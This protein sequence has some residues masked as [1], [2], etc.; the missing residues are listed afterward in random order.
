[1]GGNFGDNNLRKGAQSLRQR[2]ES[3]RFG[4]NPNAL[5]DQ[6]EAGEMEA[7]RADFMSHNIYHVPG[8]FNVIV[9]GR[10]MD[11]MRASKMFTLYDD[12]DRVRY[13]NPGA[14]CRMES[15]GIQAQPQRVACRHRVLKG[16]ALI[17][18]AG[19]SS[20]ITG[21]AHEVRGVHHMGDIEEEYLQPQTILVVQLYRR[22]KETKNYKKGTSWI[23]EF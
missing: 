23:R 13:K 22:I 19:S 6:Y 2:I 17:T 15:N 3:G 7:T 14:K 8:G 20:R 11:G 5:G 21:T 1:M 9:D 16:P 12:R 18:T 10:E 4:P